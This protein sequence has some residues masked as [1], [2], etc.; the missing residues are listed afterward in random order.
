MIRAGSNLLRQTLSQQQ[1]HVGSFCSAGYASNAFTATLFPGD[2]PPSF[3][4]TCIVSLP[5][6][7]SAHARPARHRPQ[8]WV[9]KSPAL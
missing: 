5:D 3:A 7:C 1:S 2:G 8:A 6:M 4:D 9:P